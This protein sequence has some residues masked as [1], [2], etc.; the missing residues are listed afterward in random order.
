[1]DKIVEYKNKT[2][3]FAF[4][5]DTEVDLEESFLAEACDEITFRFYEIMSEIHDEKIP[6]DLDGFIDEYDLYQDFSDISLTNKYITFITHDDV[7][8]SVNRNI[9]LPDEH[10]CL[11]MQMIANFIELKHNDLINF[12]IVERLSICK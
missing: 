12:L 2:I 1:M 11:A 3:K 8:I 10:I 4:P 9:G 6:Y 5:I 7:S